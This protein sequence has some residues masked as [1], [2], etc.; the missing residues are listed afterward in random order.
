MGMRYIRIA[1][2]PP[3]VKDMVIRNVLGT[4]GDITEIKEELW[5][6]RYCY[7]LSNE[8][9]IVNMNLKHLI[10]FHMKIEEHRFLI[11]HEGQHP[12]CY[13]CNATGY[14]H[15]FIYCPSR[16]RETQQANTPGTNT[17]AVIA[18]KINTT[19]DILCPSRKRETQQVG[20]PCTNTWAA[21]AGQTNTPRETYNKQ[22]SS[23]K[24]AEQ[25]I[26][27]KMTDNTDMSHQM[28]EA[29]LIDETL[30]TLRTEE[31]PDETVLPITDVKDNENGK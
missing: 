3:E 19:R 15:I 10:R 4:Y 22:Q 7:K 28:D 2:L 31:E 21:I 12:T 25:D 17:W 13:G 29:S 14:Q 11:S 6:N 18:A 23:E 5:T 27:E 30:K 16:K 1:N 20:T 26:G 24:Q 9:R 8:I